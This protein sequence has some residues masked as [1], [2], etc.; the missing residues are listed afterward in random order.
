MHENLIFFKPTVP[1]Q[2]SGSLMKL[3]SFSWKMR[4]PVFDAGS[5]TDGVLQFFFLQEVLI[6]IELS[7]SV[8]QKWI[9]GALKSHG[10]WHFLNQPARHCHSAGGK[11]SAGFSFMIKWENSLFSL[12]PHLQVWDCFWCC[13]QDWHGVEKSVMTFS[14]QQWLKHFWGHTL[15]GRPRS[16]RKF[17]GKLVRSCKLFS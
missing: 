7:S 1:N 11:M 2:P 16:R 17:H 3:Q 13:V 10:E 9:M 15:I 6:I 8:M 4:S 14:F 5:D 12:K